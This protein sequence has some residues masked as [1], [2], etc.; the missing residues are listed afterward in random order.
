MQCDTVKYQDLEWC[1]GDI[2][3]PGIRGIVRAIAKRDIL[4]WPT[5]P[6]T[7]LT[8]MAVLA[9]YSG[10]FIL[11]AGA[12]WK[13]VGVIVDKSPV[14]SKSQGVRPSKSFLN[15]APFTPRNW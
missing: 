4:K 1:D 12:V 14:E 7:A 6:R 13:N 15:T 9:T 3:L 10:D 11:A 5:L 8:D 2:N